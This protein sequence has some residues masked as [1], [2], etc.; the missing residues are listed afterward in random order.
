MIICA[1][2]ATNTGSKYPPSKLS[3]YCHLLSV[4]KQQCRLLSRQALSLA[5]DQTCLWPWSISPPS[6]VQSRG[7]PCLHHDGPGQ[8]PP[9]PAMCNPAIAHACIMMAN[10]QDCVR[11]PPPMRSTST[12]PL[13]SAANSLRPRLAPRGENIYR[14]RTPPPPPRKGATNCTCI[15]PPHPPEGGCLGYGAA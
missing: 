5:V 14:C 11:P 9:I 8:S 15:S 2:G 10:R 12:Q 13:L 3:N 7:P 4:I 6:D 1:L